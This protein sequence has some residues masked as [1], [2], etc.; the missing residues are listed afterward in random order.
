MNYLL[1]RIK[2][3]NLSYIQRQP[4]SEQTALQRLVNN[5]IFYKEKERNLAPIS[6]EQRSEIEAYWRSLLKFNVQD[7]VNMKFYD[8]YNNVCPDK[9]KLKYYIPDSFFYAFIDEFYTNP[10]RSTNLD[11]K[12][13]YDLYFADVN[14]PVTIARKVND[15]F[16]D[17]DYNQ[18]TVKDFVE[19]CENE[20]EVIVK[21]SICSYG[22]HGVKFWKAGE[23]TIEQLLSFVYERNSRDYI[24]SNPYQQYIVQGIVQQHS[25]MASLNLSSLNTVRVITLVR[26]GNVKVLSSVLRMG[27]AGS[28]VDNCSSG[29]I[30][31]GIDENGCLKN[32]AYNALGDKFHEHPDTGE[33]AGFIVPAL[34]EIKD[35]AQKLALRFCGVSKMISWDFAVDKEESPCLIEM[36]ISFGEIDFHQLC[37]GPIFG[38]ETT[39]I[40]KNVIDH[41]KTLNDLLNKKNFDSYIDEH[42]N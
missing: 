36:N 10:Q 16:L 17:K 6:N 15:I 40:L 25:A 20:G 14:R 21:S 11:D 28:R 19:K 4:F 42:R 30:V 5:D 41:N 9:T 12:G 33:F 7:F 35:L 22:G 18:I 2:G 29:G 39:D 24:G 27:I 23:D 37:N 3:I 34:K 32:A 8:V 13:L 26:D 31:A 1:E 38:E